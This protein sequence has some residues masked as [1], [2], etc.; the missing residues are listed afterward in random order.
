MPARRQEQAPASGCF[1]TPRPQR[2]AQRATRFPIQHAPLERRSKPPP[3]SARRTTATQSFADAT[4]CRRTPGCRSRPSGHR[5]RRRRSSRLQPPLW[6]WR[7]RRPSPSMRAHRSRAWC[8]SRGRAS[9]ARGNSRRTSATCC[10]IR[11][12][13]CRWKVCV[14]VVHAPGGMASFSPSLHPAPLVHT[15]PRVHIPHPC[16]APVTL[17]S[18]CIAS[19]TPLADSV[20]VRGGCPPP[21]RLPTHTRTH[22]HTHSH[23]RRVA[24]GTPQLHRA[25]A[26]GGDGARDAGAPEGGEQTARRCA[27]G[28]HRA[29]PD[30]RHQLLPVGAA[31]RQPRGLLLPQVRLRSPPFAA[32]PPALSLSRCSLLSNPAAWT[33][34]YKRGEHTL[35]R[36]FLSPCAL[37][38]IVRLAF[39][40]CAMREAVWFVRSLYMIREELQW[41]ITCVRISACRSG[42]LPASLVST[43]SASGP[44]LGACEGDADGAALG[45]TEWDALGACDGDMLGA[46]EGD[47]L[48]AF[49]R[50]LS[51]TW[52]PAQ[53][54]YALVHGCGDAGAFRHSTGTGCHYRMHGLPGALRVAVRVARR[55]LTAAGAVDAGGDAN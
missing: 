19:I 49:C 36:L 8:G 13:T 31:G 6:W 26:A 45:A 2:E 51:R 50:R 9:S 34:G 35:S 21:S 41:D 7:R 32:L 15:P 44:A 27:G 10:T 18:G 17:H 12:S 39:I 3:P 52:G 5:R 29:A 20:C 53:V 22:H 30:V 37:H 48:G 55:P 4:P 42:Q 16:L 54:I 33:V 47:S 38:R 23:Q 25:R 28:G 43:P 11:A 46:T 14:C 1:Y 24:V 40:R